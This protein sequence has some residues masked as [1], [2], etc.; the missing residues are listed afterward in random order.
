VVRSGGYQ[1]HV[2][3]AV[4]VTALV[5]APRHFLGIGRQIR[6]GLLNVRYWRK[7]DI[8]WTADQVIVLG[9][10]CDMQNVTGNDISPSRE[11]IFEFY[12]PS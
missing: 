10:F 4:G 1:R 11:L 2:L 3:R 5:F 9:E 12:R 8:G 7:A 6:G